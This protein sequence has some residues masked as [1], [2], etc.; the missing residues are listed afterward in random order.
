MTA[1]DIILIQRIFEI[2]YE[3]TVDEEFSNLT[4]FTRF[5]V[6][7]KTSTKWY[8][9]LYNFEGHVY[10]VE[11]FQDLVSEIFFPH[12]NMR[13]RQMKLHGDEIE[14]LLDTRGGLTEEERIDME[15]HFFTKNF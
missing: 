4:F 14:L 8:S 2:Q 10:P 3:F 11:I 1:N 5:Q 12:Q 9:V 7:P 6:K 15:E 13:I